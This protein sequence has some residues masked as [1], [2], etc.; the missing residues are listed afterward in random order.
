M[1]LL[2]LCLSTVVRAQYEQGDETDL[3]LEEWK[4]KPY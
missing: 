4:K 3:Q 2:L 1:D